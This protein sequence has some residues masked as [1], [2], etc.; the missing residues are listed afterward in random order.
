MTKTARA[1]RQTARIVP[2]RKGTTLEMVRRECL[3]AILDTSISGR[4][5]A[6]ELTDLISRR[7]KPDMIVSDHGT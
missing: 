5:V 6:R 2:L 7:G 1:P 4:R 3:A